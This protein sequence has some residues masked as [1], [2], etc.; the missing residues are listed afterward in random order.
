MKRRSSLWTCPQC[1]RKFAQRR[2]QHA[3]GRW[4]VAERFEGR[5]RELR[6]LFDEFVKLL[7]SN[8]PVRLHPTKTR[9]GFIARMTFAAATVQRDR[10]QC[11]LILSRRIERRRFVKIETYSPRCFLHQF[12]IR[13]DADLDDELRQ[14]VAEAYQVGMKSMTTHRS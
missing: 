9:I 11:H 10:L 2:Q 12:F 3:C 5:P 14:L 1:G 7:R 4:T 8:G 6:A 13:G